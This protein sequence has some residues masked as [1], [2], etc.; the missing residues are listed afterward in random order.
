MTLGK[1]INIFPP[2][3]MTNYIKRHNDFCL[4]IGGDS[5]PLFHKEPLE[6]NKKYFIEFMVKKGSCSI[7]ITLNNK[8]KDKLVHKNSIY[9]ETE[10]YGSLRVCGDL[11]HIQKNKSYIKES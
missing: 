5:T 7:G 3:E 11:M 10:G 8:Q 9:Y 1:R 6:S 2:I 4:K